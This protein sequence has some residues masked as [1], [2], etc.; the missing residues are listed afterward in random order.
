[1]EQNRKIG[2]SQA[3]STFTETFGLSRAAA[4]GVMAV[5]SALTIVAVFY[6]IHSAPPRTLIITTGPAGSTFQRNAE[7]YRDILSSNG[8]TLRILTSQ[9]SMENLQRLA[10]PGFR[11]DIGFVQAGQTNGGGGAG[12]F[13]LG[14]V[15]YQPL[16]IFYRS[17]TPVN[18]LSDL[19]GKRLAIGPP[20][21]GTR[22]LALL[23]LGTNG[24]VPGGAT[25]LLEVDTQEGAKAFLD[26]KA[27]AVFLMGDSASSQTMRTLLRSPG[28]QLFSF[29]QADAY[30]RRFAFLNK[31][32]LPRGA[33]DLGKD[34]PS[35]DVTLIG[36]TVE[37]VARAN[38]HPALSDLLLEAAETV[39]GNATLL[40]RRGEFPAPLEQEFKISPDAGR[41]YKS[42]K[43]FLYRSLPFWL[44]S[45]MNRVLVVFIPLVLVLIP[46]LRLLPT[47]YKWRIQLRIYRW[48][49]GLLRVERDL[50]GEMTA[51]KREELQQRLDQIEASVNQMRVPASF[52]GQFYGLR[53]HIGFVRERLQRR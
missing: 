36:P 39:H 17:S 20:G 40:Q 33:I 14:S 12:L 26:G 21:S 47:A 34:I 10:D 23:L 51:A 52:A 38:L 53:E 3:L 32:Q 43:K 4:I 22:T 15:A 11:V 48:Y 30:T 29:A 1:M 45:L 35:H 25:T 13:S 46:S 7:R 49:R 27:D 2:I 44:A 18:L 8:V 28:V 42:G 41:Y 16:M 50:F 31:L 6:F 37:L 24:I 19:A 5:T 9:G